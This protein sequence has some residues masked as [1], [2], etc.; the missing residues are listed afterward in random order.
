MKSW[1]KSTLALIAALTVC[2]YAGAEE[3]APRSLV[4]EK[5]KAF[6]EEQKAARQEHHQGNRKEAEEFRAGLKDKAPNEVA[7]ALKAR[8]EAEYAQ[9]K[10]FR[11][12][13]YERRV[14]FVKQMMAENDVPVEKQ[15]EALAK[16]AANHAEAVAHFAQQHQENM[17]MLAAMAADGELTRED[18]ADALKQQRNLQQGEN[19]SYF[20]AKRAEWKATR[21]ARCRQRQGSE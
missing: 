16:M 21:E 9:N 17:A 2:G 19:K 14:A 11:E 13:Q 7:A 20:E 15:S 10:S 1:T 3:E 8:R 6:R 5:V 18:F 4:R 12:A